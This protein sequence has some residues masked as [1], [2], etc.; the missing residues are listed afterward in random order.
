[1]RTGVQVYFQNELMQAKAA[2]LLKQLSCSEH[3]VSEN[4]G[5]TDGAGC[6][7]YI[8]MRGCGPDFYGFVNSVRCDQGSL[9]THVRERLHKAIAEM[10]RKRHVTVRPQ[11][12]RDVTA[13][14]VVSRIVNPRFTSQAKTNLATPVR[15]LGFTVDLPQRMLT[16]LQKLGVLDEIARRENERELSASLKKTMVPKCKELFIEK[17]VSVSGGGFVAQAGPAPVLTPKDRVLHRGAS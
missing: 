2:L 5:N 15:Q 13:L 11:T 17:Y 6:T 4:F 12:V 14:L 9:S 3:V 10:M 16:K 1:M 8:A 7:L